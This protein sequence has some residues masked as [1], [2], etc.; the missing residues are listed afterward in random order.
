MTV[1]CG[2]SSAEASAR[3]VTISSPEMAKKSV[4]LVVNIRYP[5]ARGGQRDRAGRRRCEG[6][7][8][9]RGRGCR[10]RQRV[11]PSIGPQPASALRGNEIVSRYRKIMVGVAQ[12]CESAR[13]FRIAFV[14]AEGA[15]YGPLEGC[16]GPVRLPRWS[17]HAIIIILIIQQVKRQSQ[18]RTQ[19]ALEAEADVI[20]SK[21]NCQ[22]RDM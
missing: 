21:P 15:D 18:R 16:L 20:M 14:C 1:V 4:L 19:H 8:R 5:H 13:D 12:Q 22:D 9:P 3:A 10:H 17:C 6:R 11:G 2:P 7:H